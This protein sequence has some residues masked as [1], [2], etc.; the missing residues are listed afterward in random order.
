MA[1]IEVGKSSEKK[2][3]R[4]H[5][6]KHCGGCYKDKAYLKKHIKKVHLGLQK[7]QCKLCNKLLTSNKYLQEHI[8]AV[9]EGFKQYKCEQCEGN[10]SFIGGLR[11]HILQV[12]GNQEL[13]RV[14]H[15]NI[16]KK[17]FK[18]K[19]CLAMHVDAKHDQK[20]KKAP[21]DEFKCEI[22]EKSFNLKIYLERHVKWKHRKKVTNVTSAPLL[23]Q[24][25]IP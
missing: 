2:N 18:S 23:F 20:L 8:K 25:N 13:L 6:C 5:E 19:R 21:N 24:L 3:L 10:F 4:S 16:C 22:C 15:C 12:H 7:V 9:H 14:Y 1:H 11:T 17:K